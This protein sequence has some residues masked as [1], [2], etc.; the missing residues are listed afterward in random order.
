MFQ[1]V[2]NAAKVTIPNAAAT[3]SS[4]VSAADYGSFKYISS[5][6]GNGID[7]TNGVVVPPVVES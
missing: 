2:A 4:I 6:Q 5:S 3:V 1:A 7:K